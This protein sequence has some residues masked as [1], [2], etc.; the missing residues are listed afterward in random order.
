MREHP[1]RDCIYAESESVIGKGK[2][3]AELTHAQMSLYRAAGFP[4]KW[5][6]GANGIIVRD[7]SNPE[8]WDINERWWAEWKKGVTRD[9]L[10]LMYCFWQ[11]GWYPD[12][13][14]VGTYFKKGKHNK[15]GIN[16]SN[17]KEVETVLVAN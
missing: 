1:H 2:A 14:R 16:E 11:A 7:L 5:G 6:L 17:R 9:Q 12:W 10:S 15:I 13:I 8:V 3:E 4:E